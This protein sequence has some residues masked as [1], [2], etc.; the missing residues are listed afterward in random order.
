[1]VNRCCL[2][3]TMTETDQHAPY[4]S[5]PDR[6][7]LHIAQHQDYSASVWPQGL[8]WEIRRQDGEGEITA[9]NQQSF[10]HITHPHY[11]SILLC[12][13]I[14]N[15]FTAKMWLT[16]TTN[17]SYSVKWY[18][19]LSLPRRDLKTTNNSKKFENLKPIFLVHAGVWKGLHQNA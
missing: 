16:H 9:C 15:P 2:C 3:F 6:Q 10:S 19:T 11:Q 14:L 8:C 7:Y 1:M 13:M 12:K 4:S 5:S 17:P 18:L